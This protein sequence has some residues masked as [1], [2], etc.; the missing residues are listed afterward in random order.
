MREDWTLHYYKED[1]D[2]TKGL[3]EALTVIDNLVGM[4]AGIMAAQP[5]ITA[6]SATWGAMGLLSTT[7]SGLIIR[8]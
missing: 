8:S 5:A 3:K 7:L 6:I 4:F 1:S 2:A